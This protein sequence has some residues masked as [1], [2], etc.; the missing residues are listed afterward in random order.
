M[1]SAKGKPTN[2]KLKEKVTEGTYLHLTST[3]SFIC[4]PNY[5]VSIDTYTEVKQQPNKDGSG[6][7]QM[8]ARKVRLLPP[9]QI[10]LPSN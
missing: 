7:G 6:K 9:T 5:M 1:P 10:F 4:V 8:A 3:L 2:P